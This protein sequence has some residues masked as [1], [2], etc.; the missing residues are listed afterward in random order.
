MV[1]SSQWRLKPQL[2]CPFGLRLGGIH[3]PQQARPI[4]EMVGVWR[5]PGSK[6]HC[7]SVRP[8]RDCRE[9]GL[10]QSQ[11]TLHLPAVRLTCAGATMDSGNPP[12]RLGYYLLHAPF[13][14]FF[15]FSSLKQIVIIIFFNVR[16]DIII[17]YH[18]S[19]T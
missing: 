15:L 18:V 9:S 17:C 16:I 5:A 13:S 19:V 3:C 10:P 6:P 2:L 8:P 12:R 4:S 1:R 7:V 14:F 11:S